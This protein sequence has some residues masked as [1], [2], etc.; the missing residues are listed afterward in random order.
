MILHPSL[1]PALRD[2]LAAIRQRQRVDDVVKLILE[3]ACALADAAHGSF[4]LVDHEAGRL[5]IGQVFG[6]D[7]TSEK[8]LCQLPIGQGLTGRVASTGQPLLCPDTT[9]HPDYYPLFDH[10]RSELVVPVFV[11]NKVWGLINIDK[12]TPHAFDQTTLK[13]LTVFAELAA[14]AITLRLELS[15]QDKL[16]QKLLQSEKLASLGEALAGIAH[17][18]NNPLTAILGF[19][20]LL[21]LEP[22]GKSATNAVHVIR[23]ESERA[24][25]LIK[26]VLEFSRKESG[27]RQFADLNDIVRQVVALKKFHFKNSP[28]KLVVSYEDAHCPVSVC[29][30]QIK[31][32]LINLITNAEQAMPE[33]RTGVITLTVGAQSDRVFVLVA[34][35]GA[36]IPTES[37]RFIFDPFFTTKAP[38]QGTGLGLSIAH[39]IMEAHGGR[40]RLGSSSA[41][42]TAFIL[43]LPL[44]S[45]AAMLLEA[46]PA[47]LADAS[48]A[49]RVLVIDDEPHILEALTA[50][51]TLFNLKV[52]SATDGR[53][54]LARLASHRFDVIVSDIRMPVMDG[55]EL[56]DRARQFDPRYEKRFVFM[57]GYLLRENTKAFLATSG[58]PYLEKP[59]SFDELRRMIAPYLPAPLVEAPAPVR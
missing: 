12:P 16:Y 21:E 11:D 34:D 58:V 3:R 59:F 28:L 1:L 55:I 13:L 2:V 41:A 6:A 25:V 47:A 10:V 50:Y 30:Q 33:K 18:I 36:G 32:V 5:S 37:R 45:E 19:T 43:E 23:S 39:S 17:E 8:K 24:A 7:W 22:L 14:Y 56:Y 35:N 52:H 27:R 38:G 40:I 15:E 51:L 57:S 44:A 54:A 49:G 53:T 29:P 4:V 48:L 26:G 20:S 42:G 31:Q 46:N 9:L